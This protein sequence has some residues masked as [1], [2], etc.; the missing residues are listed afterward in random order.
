MNDIECGPSLK[1][2]ALA[3]LRTGDSSAVPAG[4]TDRIPTGIASLDAQIGGGSRPG[5]LEVLCAYTGSGKSSYSVFRSMVAVEFGY[6]VILYRHQMPDYEYWQRF[7][8]FHTGQNY[9]EVAQFFQKPMES[10]V[11]INFRGKE[12]MEV[13]HDLEN[14]TK[15]VA[16]ERQITP[17]VVVDSMDVL[18]TDRLK[19]EEIAE[20]LA[21]IAETTGAVIMAT[22][23]SNDSGKDVD[24]VTMTCLREAKGKAIPASLFLGLGMSQENK[25]KG[26]VTFTC[27]K[28]RHGRTFQVRAGVNFSK[29]RF[30][31][32]DDTYEIP[33]IVLSEDLRQFRTMDVNPA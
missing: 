21:T 24:T 13:L 1:N 19:L 22:S 12:P 33:D 8:A 31:D 28:N 25:D 15:R 23:Q 17:L 18:S 9:S 20:R 2:G 16:D 29:Q 5:S 7:T 27:D 14:D 26:V 10:V 3:G 11:L 32:L 4:T 6:P 30:F